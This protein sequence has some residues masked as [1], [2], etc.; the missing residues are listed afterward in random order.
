MKHGYLRILFHELLRIIYKDPLSSVLI[1][2]FKEFSLSI[3][4]KT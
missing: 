2:N 1:F 4:D 3:I